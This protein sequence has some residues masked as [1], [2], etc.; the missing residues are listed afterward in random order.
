MPSGYRSR[1]MRARRREKRQRWQLLLLYAV[2][3]VV[4]LGAV[5]GAYFLARALTSAHHTDPDRGRMVLLVVGGR[6]SWAPSAGLALYD[7]ARGS[8]RL[9]TIPRD[10]LL[11]GPRG[12]Y[13]LAGDEMRTGALRR[14]L[15]RLIGVVLRDELHIGYEDLVALAGDGP[16]IV[17][18]D[19]PVE[20]RIDGVWRTYEGTL[21]VAPDEAARLM[22]AEGRSGEDE[23]A[24]ARAVLTAIL[25]AGA[26]RPKDQRTGLVARLTGNV[27]DE[28]RALA[29]RRA[30]NGLLAGAVDVKTFPS[31]AEV[32]EG[33]F[34]FRPDRSAVMTEITRL[35]PGYSARYTI[36]IRNGTGEA[37]IGGLVRQRL[38]VLDATLPTPTNAD[39]FHYDRTEILAGSEALALAEDVRAILGRGVVLSGADL[40]ERTLVVIVGADLQARDLQ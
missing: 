28:E 1:H 20:L 35:A 22:A 5:V 29:F 13:V 21:E 10:L 15:G 14:D 3:P 19:E 24:V 12:E 39:S 18:L 40:P 36:I 4:A 8:Y 25:H 23:D 17:R 27:R 38:A 33:Q 9:Y 34:A 31:Y 30:L 32:A 2:A 37:G 16:L 6:T 11:E 7:P 26:L